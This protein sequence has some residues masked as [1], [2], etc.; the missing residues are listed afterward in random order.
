MEDMGL[1]VHLL[2]PY[3]AQNDVLVLQQKGQS[4]TIF[5]SVPYFNTGKLNIWDVLFFSSI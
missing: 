2:P 5:F 4:R 1:N 3:A